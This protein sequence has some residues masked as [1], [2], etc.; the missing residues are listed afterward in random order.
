MWSVFFIVL[1]LQVITLCESFS[2]FNLTIKDYRKVEEIL[3]CNEN[4]LS[5]N[6]KIRKKNPFQIILKGQT[7]VVVWM[8]V[9]VMSIKGLCSLCVSA[10]NNPQ[11]LADLDGDEPR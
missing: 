1:H 11:L 3:T 9:L 5:R 6:R 4:E 2:F 7:T 10:W 8:V